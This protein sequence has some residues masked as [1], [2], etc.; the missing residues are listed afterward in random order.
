MKRRKMPA[1]RDF[2]L[3]EVDAARLPKGFYPHRHDYYEVIW[4]HAGA[5]RNIVDFVDHPLRRDRVFFMAPDQV[6]ELDSKRSSSTFIAFSRGFVSSVKAGRGADLDTAL[7]HAHAGAPFIDARGDDGDTMRS[8]LAL[9][10]SEHARRRSS[11]AILQSLLSAFL[12]AALRIKGE[13]DGGGAHPDERVATL[14]RAIEASYLS[15]RSTAF[16]AKRVGLTAKRINEITRNALGKTVAQLLNDRIV[17]QAKR[18]LHFTSRSIKEIAHG[19]GYEDPAYF[20]RFFKRH[21][22]MTPREFRASRDA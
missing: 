8:L 11:W 12:L 2:S 19:L 7:F 20:S 16:Y 6:H 17:L 3:F 9:M 18:D 14:R 21:A 15:Q 22:G 1:E 13:H 5:G 10:R 4:C